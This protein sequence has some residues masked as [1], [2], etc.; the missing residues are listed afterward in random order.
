[1]PSGTAGRL[2]LLLATVVALGC[3]RQ[4]MEDP[5]ESMRAALERTAPERV[6]ALEPGSPEEEAALA[7]FADFVSDMSVERTPRLALE[8]Y[9]DNVYFDDTLKQV[10]GVEALAEYF[11][12]SLGGAEEVTAE[13]LDVARS[14][15][16][17]YVRWEMMIRFR[18]LADNQPT[19]STGM[20]HLRFDHEGRVV[21]HQ[22][23]WDSTSG[24]FQ[25]VPVVGR[26]IGWVKGRL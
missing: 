1:M 17:Y 3:N 20:S 14:G 5:L 4:P 13:V 9:A 19:W 18:K 7:R 10:Q 26:L 6:G 22:D 2:G 24:F 11:R 16:D 8:V 21:F 23:H 25:Y 12:H 15:S